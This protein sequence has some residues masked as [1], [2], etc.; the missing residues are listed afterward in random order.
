MSSL[1][2]YLAKDKALQERA[3]AEV[4]AALGKEDPDLVNMRHLPFTQA[5]IREA[6]RINTPIVRPS[7]LDENHPYRPE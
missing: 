2:Y 7:T 5:C 1:V 6:L 3:R 4:I